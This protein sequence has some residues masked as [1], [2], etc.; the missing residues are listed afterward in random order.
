[1]LYQLSYRG[2]AVGILLS[3]GRRFKR[4]GAIANENLTGRTPGGSLRRILL[5]RQGFSIFNLHFEI[6]NLQWYSAREATS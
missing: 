5:S 2:E 1:M 3:A 6:R 4:R